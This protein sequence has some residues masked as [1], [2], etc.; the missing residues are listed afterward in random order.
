MLDWH[1]C[2]VNILFAHLGFYGVY[3]FTDCLFKT[4]RK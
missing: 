1:T 3:Y 4:T 2:V